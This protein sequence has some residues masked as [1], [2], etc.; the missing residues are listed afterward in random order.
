MDHPKLDYTV[1]PFQYRGYRIGQET[2][3]YRIRSEWYISPTGKG[4][5]DM[6]RIDQYDV[7]QILLLY[8]KG[9]M[10]LKQPELKTSDLAEVANEF[11]EIVTWN[12]YSQIFL[13]HREQQVG[14]IAAD[15]DKMLIMADR[16]E[17]L[18]SRWCEPLRKPLT[19]GL[20]VLWFGYVEK[21]Q[22]LVRYIDTSG[23]RVILMEFNGTN[24]VPA[25]H[26]SNVPHLP[27][28]S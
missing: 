14:P 18:G 8:E 24:W 28:L 9:K 2:T 6:H 17:E 27:H 20:G 26:P 19:I 10:N 22:S 11:G 25:T 15:E 23:F 7:S 5:P 16:L 13:G 12:T 21:Q 4:Y 3:V 1:E